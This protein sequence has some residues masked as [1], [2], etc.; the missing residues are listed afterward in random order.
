MGSGVPEPPSCGVGGATAPPIRPH[1]P[2]YYRIVS[3]ASVP[4][5]V[6]NRVFGASQVL[7]VVAGLC[8]ILGVLFPGA[9]I[10]WHLVIAVGTFAALG[11]SAARLTLFLL[12]GIEGLARA[13]AGFTIAV[14]L[15]AV[16]ATWLGHFGLLSP[17]AVH[18]VVFAAYCL[19]RFLR[20][21]VD[22][23]QATPGG[24]GDARWNRPELAVLVGAGAVFA[25]ILIC[26]LV[27]RRLE[28]PGFRAYDDTSYH[29]SA[30]ATWH[31]FEDLRMVKFPVGDGGT[32]FYPVLG[33][34]W[35]FLL[36]APVAPSDF[37]ARWVELPFALFSLV[38]LAAVG[39]A[40]G[41]SGRSLVVAVLLYAATPRAFPGLM[42]TA[43]NDHMTS[44]L[45]L[46]AVLSVLLLAQRRSVGRA[47]FAGTCLGLL[48]GVKYT[49]L[50][51]CLP[52]SILLLVSVL[53]AP[54]ESE[55]AEEKW[56]HRLL[57]L[58]VAIGVAG[59]TG[60]YTYLRNTVSTGNPVFPATIAVLGRTLLQGW[61]TGPWSERPEYPIRPVAFLLGNADLF[62]VLFRF[63]LLPA[64]IV[65][66]LAALFIRVRAEVRIRTALTLALPAVFYLEFLRLMIDHRDIRY[67][68]GAIALAA[69]AAAWLVERA[70]QW[71]PVARSA[72]ALAVTISLFSSARTFDVSGP[73]LLAHAV[74]IA[75][76]FLLGERVRRETASR[77]L[78]LGAA[79]SVSLV[80]LLFPVAQAVQT[81]QE[82]KFQYESAAADLEERTRLRGAAVAYVGWNQ[83]YF[84]WGARLQNRVYYVPSSRDPDGGF[85]RWGGSPAFPGSDPSYSAWRKNLSRL[86]IRYVVVA[87]EGREMPEL[88]WIEMEPKRFLSV[89]R[90]A[91]IETFEVREPPGEGLSVVSIDAASPR[92][93]SYLGDGWFRDGSFPD[94]GEAVLVAPA[95]GASI[96]V[97]PLDRGLSAVR[98]TLARREPGVAVEV[99]LDGATIG[100]IP[101]GATA[102]QISLEVQDPSPPRRLRTIE[103]VTRPEAVP[104]GPFQIGTTGL[105]VPVPIVV[106]SAGYGSGNVARFR[107]GGEVV[108]KSERGYNLVVRA[109]GSAST[110]A[111]KSFDTFESGKA[112]HDMAEFLGKLPSG[113]IVLGA[114]SDEASRS[115]A[116]EGVEALHRLGCRVDLRGRFRWSHAFIGVVGA[117]TGTVPE[118]AD[119]VVSAVSTGDVSVV[120]RRIE[121]V[122]AGTGTINGTHPPG[123]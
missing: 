27:T 42:L 17:R 92:V 29:L 41:L 111:A 101:A 18:L 102:G 55:F 95:K 5:R 113:A 81:Y 63:T 45:S 43:G 21:R 49:G 47:V 36:L 98:F 15:G 78:F 57:I 65:A 10:R 35:S 33:E 58:V 46:A 82:G 69:V 37:L 9:G 73:R 119:P 103:L 122:H 12:P 86:G 71:A 52:L 54:G 72:V 83:P 97:P 89:F 79:G 90:D 39:R 50:I 38:G 59:A 75:G 107:I 115:L 96:V 91:R 62:G 70:G 109:P 4:S 61:D 11:L 117:E 26:I 60:G 3:E 85:Y 56:G 30:M 118:W 106:E 48:A 1:S 80:V 53:V 23:P 110:L 93:R 28:A 6:G 116:P 20:P 94:G 40:L 121:L 108:T 8:P 112:S 120:L 44:F 31:S 74:L 114:V 13:A 32:A 66:P 123:R 19:T 87:Y 105:S 76:V 64:A 88:A 84:Y 34:I 67:F 2:G 7:S 68:L 51:Y 24:S 25:G 14:A 99:R 100:E 22:A 77:R 104:K 16:P